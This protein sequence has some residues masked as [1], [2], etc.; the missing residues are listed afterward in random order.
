VK[1]LFFVDFSTQKLKS[2]KEIVKTLK[3]VLVGTLFV[4]T[5]FITISIY[6]TFKTYLIRK[7]AYIDNLTSLYNRNYLQDIYDTINLDEFDIALIDIDYFKKINDSY[8]HDV[9]DIVLK[10]VAIT[11]KK[12]I[13]NKEDIVIRYGGEEFLLFLKKSKKNKYATLNVLNRIWQ[14]IRNLNIKTKEEKIKVS[15]SIGVNL[16]AFK[17][18]TLADAIKKADIALYQAKN[19]GRDRIE[20][21]EETK[22]KSIAIQYLKDLIE[23]KKIICYYQVI[24]DLKENKISHFEALARIID[25]KGKIIY[26]NEFLPVLSGGFLYSKFTKAVIEY[27]IEILKKYPDIKI[28]INLSP[29]DIFDESIIYILKEIDKELRN[30]IILEIVETEDIHSYDLFI[31]NV[32]KLKKEYGYKICIDNFGAGYSNFTHLLKINTDYLKLDGSIIKNIHKDKIS[33][34]LAETITTFCKK[35]NIKTVA[36]YVE[37]NQILEKVRELNIDYGQGFLFY[38][39]MPIEEAVKLIKDEDQEYEENIFE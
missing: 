20:I 7:K 8:G 39:A 32:V 2:I 33:Y 26:P 25:D 21:Y 35:M 37:N 5:F 23:N 12:S 38:K 9:G 29:S 4:I 30:R 10:E 27:N 34:D 31:D 14:S 13:R 36:E 22:D 3:N 24:I 17:S 19:K 15:I 16:D 6:N 1:A 11:I 28:A 18:G